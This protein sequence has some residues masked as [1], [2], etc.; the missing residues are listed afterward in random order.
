MFHSGFL[1]NSTSQSHF[2]VLKM[3]RLQLYQIVTICIKDK[4]SCSSLNVE[5][6]CAMYG[7]VYTGTR[8]CNSRPDIDLYFQKLSL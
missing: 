1:E 2:E 7:H 6:R 4:L 3:I 8:E 5:H